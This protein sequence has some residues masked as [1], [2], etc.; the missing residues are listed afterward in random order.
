MREALIVDA[1][2][3]PIG[4][5]KPGGALS[6]IHPVDLHAHVLKAVVDRTGVDPS[7]LDDVIGGAVGQVGEQSMNTTPIA[8]T[9]HPAAAA[10]RGSLAPIA[11]PT[12][13]APAEASPSGIM[14]ATAA[15]LSAIW[16]DAVATGSSLP[17]S[18][19][20]TAKTPTSAVTVAA[21]GRPNSTSRRMDGLL[22]SA[23]LRA[24]SLPCPCR[25]SR[26][27]FC[28]AGAG[29]PDRV[30]EVHHTA[31]TRTALM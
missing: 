17:A 5:G 8:I 14:N 25:A 22:R 31:T 29:A 3:T 10:P 28:G 19:V 7:Y 26:V 11:L 9:V 12:R 1:V 24:R 27:A 18:A 20:A 23:K 30:F 21:A 15:M 16:C 2:R 6:E 13:T 4:K